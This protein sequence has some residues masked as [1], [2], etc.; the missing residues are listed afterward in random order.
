MNMKKNALVAM[1]F[2]SSGLNPNMIEDMGIM[3]GG[4]MGASIANQSISAMYQNMSTAM[5]KEQSNI[6]NS[7][8]SFESYVNKAQSKELLDI[9]QFFKTAQSHIVNFTS[10]QSTIMHQMETYILKAVSLNQ[11]QS[12]YLSNPANLDQFFTLGT[13]YTPKG[14]IWKNVFPVGNWQY[15][16][17]TDSFWQMDS[18]PLL[19]QET[20]ATTG[21]VSTTAHKAPNNS[22]FT[23]WIT[24]QGSYEIICEVTLY[25]V[26]YP[27]FAGIIF[28]KARWISGD[29]QRIQQYRLLGVFG[30]SAKNASVCFAEQHTPASSVKKTAKKPQPL[31]PLQQIVDGDGVQPI[32]LSQASFA[33]ITQR[34]VSL[35][36][37][38]I[39]SPSSIK[40]KI[41][42]SKTKEPTAFTT[43]QTINEN[44]YLYHGFG[45]MSPGAVAEF[46]IIKPTGLLFPTSARIKFTAEV[47]ALLKNGVAS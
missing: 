11:P 2:I 4:Q 47:D 29:M 42:P 10:E 12:H 1:L 24:R 44:L 40:C 37:K 43:I 27:F 26:S 41:W 22:I 46:K 17:T 31:Y 34:P 21:T 23:E 19:T 35:M 36:I 28:N 13:M 3:M 25:Q 16:E 6:Q 20:N 33:S 38:I 39:T 14:H 30:N 45:F 9:L 32:T 5:T 15:D 7:M 8:S 18:Q